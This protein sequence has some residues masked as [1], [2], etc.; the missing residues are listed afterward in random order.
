MIQCQEPETYFSEM[1]FIMCDTGYEL[2]WFCVAA[3]KCMVGDG[4]LLHPNTVLA[5]SRVMYKHT[6]GLWKGQ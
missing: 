4:M 2:D 3:L 1:E 6:M 5:K